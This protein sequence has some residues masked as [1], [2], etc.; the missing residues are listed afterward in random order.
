MVG[1]RGTAAQID[2]QDVLGLVGVQLAGD[3]RDQIVRGQ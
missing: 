1:H 2:G 3:Q